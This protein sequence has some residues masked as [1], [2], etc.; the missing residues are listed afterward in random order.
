VF[1]FA[2]IGLALS[3]A[4]EFFAAVGQTI[5]AVEAQFGPGNGEQKK[6]EVV[7]AVTATYKLLD[8]GFNLPDAVD[9]AVAAAIPAIVEVVF[10]GLTKTPKDVTDAPNQ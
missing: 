3:L 2:F 6:K 8:K 5:E 10:Q 9:S 7:E 1:N 4:P